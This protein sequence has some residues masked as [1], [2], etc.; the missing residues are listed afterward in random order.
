LRQKPP[1]DAS[2]IKM[3]RVVLFLITILLVALGATWL[4]DRPG[5]LAITWQGWRIETSVMVGAIAILTVV[6]A[7]IALWSLVRLVFH[8]PGLLAR[9]FRRRKRSRGYRAISQGLIAIGAGDSRSALKYAAEAQRIASSEPLALLLSAQAAQLDGNRPAA[10]AAFRVMAERAD[11]KLLGL[12]GL[13]I[14]AQRRN[15]TIAARQFA[16]GAAESSPAAGWAAQAVL[17]FRCAAG[18]WSGALDILDRQLQG[19]GLDKAV[20]RRWRAVLLTARA[21]AAE[22]GDRDAALTLVMEAV[23][24]APDLV[25]AAALAGRLLADA[26][27][28][29][30]ASRIL[31]TAWR[32]HPHPDLAEAYAHARVADSARDRLVRIESLARQANGMDGT[33][34]GPLALARAALDAREFAVARRALGPLLARPTRRVALLMAELEELEHG[35][36]GRA[37]A[38]MTRA[39]HAERDPEWTADGFVAEHWLPVSP[40]SGRIDAFEWKV[41]LTELPAP[42][43]VLEDRAEAPSSDAPSPVPQEPQAATRPINAHPSIGQ[44]DV[45]AARP[46]DSKADDIIP[47]M[48]VPDDPGPPQHASEGED[49][50]QKRED[51]WRLG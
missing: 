19:N 39:V 44:T 27:E 18:E 5:D 2:F 7:A 25:P 22:E 43:P 14:E 3:I 24:L 32:H 47:L 31:E 34:E 23:K 10:E 26:G 4:A 48:P 11:T 42:G 9:A 45:A 51:W 41:P 36:E 6:V 1:H 50:A 20:Y 30:K 38:W 46:A 21:L 16:E 33:I 49:E 29:R 28:V 37:R 12:R 8:S 17:G 35:D 15:D 13:Y 40:I